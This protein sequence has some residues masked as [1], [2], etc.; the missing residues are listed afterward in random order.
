MYEFKTKFLGMD[1][2]VQ[3]RSLGNYLPATMTDPAEYPEIDILSVENEAGE[4]VEYDGLW[5]KNRQGVFH[6]ASG[7][8]E[9]L[10]YEHYEGE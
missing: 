8:L 9:D 1:V 2:T 3:Y 4:Q 10:A 7:W 5:F 6:P